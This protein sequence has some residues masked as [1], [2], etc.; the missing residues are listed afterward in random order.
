VPFKGTLEGSFTVSADP[1]PAINR[2]LDAWGHATQLGAFTFDF[3]H[4]VDRLVVPATGVGF[5][6]F[7]AANGDPV[8]AFIT[9]QAVLV[10]PGLL[11]GVELGTII[12]GTGRFAGATGSFVIG[13]LIDTIALTTVGS[14]EGTI[15][16]VGSGKH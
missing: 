4:S 10:G 7:T 3:A 2:Q 13:Q 12:G 9:G 6:V 15:S 5:A 8:F 11:N 1:P 14:F 16:S